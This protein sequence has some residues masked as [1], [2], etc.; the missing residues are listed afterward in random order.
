MLFIGLPELYENYMGNWCKTID[1]LYI[2]AKISKSSENAITELSNWLNGEGAEYC[3][4]TPLSVFS[5]QNRSRDGSN[6]FI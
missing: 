5:A 4:I 6:Q 2:E 3:Q 1:D